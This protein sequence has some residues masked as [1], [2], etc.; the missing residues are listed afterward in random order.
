MDWAAA[1]VGLPYR[2]GGRTPNGIDCWGLVL[3]VWREVFGIE[4]PGM[5]GVTWRPG[6]PRDAVR[7]VA[8]TMAAT[9]AGFAP[10][11]A[12]QEQAGD[13]IL[14]RMRGHPLHCAVVVEPGLMLHAVEGADSAVERYRSI[15]WEKRVLGFYRYC[16]G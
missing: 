14:I 6:E 4:G 9:A 15:M 10:V 3:L 1:Y 5:D 11:P 8:D 7:S 13:A 12:G 2:L 16:A